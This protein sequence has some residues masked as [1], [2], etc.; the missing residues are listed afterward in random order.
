MLILG[1]LLFAKANADELAQSA[2]PRKKLNTEGV[3][4]ELSQLRRLGLACLALEL[5]RHALKSF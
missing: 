5:S 2:E 3:I 4:D 1:L